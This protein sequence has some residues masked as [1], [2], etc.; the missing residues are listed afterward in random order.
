MRSKREI[1]PPSENNKKE[2]N[3]ELM[4]LLIPA[5]VAPVGPRFTTVLRIPPVDSPQSAVKVAIARPK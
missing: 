5:A 3:K 1:G 2:N 4:G